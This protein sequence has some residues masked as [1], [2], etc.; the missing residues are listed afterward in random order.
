MWEQLDPAWRAAIEEAWA[1]YGAG[2]HPIGA[3]L[4]DGNGRVL[5]RGRNHVFDAEP[6]GL[7]RRN[8]LAHA[9]MN[10]LLA[11]DYHDVDPHQCVLYTTTEPCPLCMGALYM[12]GVRSLHYAARDTWCGSTNLL[13]VTPYLA[14]KPVRVSGPLP[15]VEDLV[16]VLRI[17]FHLRQDANRATEVV[18]ASRAVSASA[19][20]LGEKLAR[21]GEL[22]SL[23]LGGVSA[24]EMVGCLSRSL[25]QR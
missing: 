22:R 21:T 20:A 3:A 9:E 7:I 18:E 12:S 6:G 13:G 17:A 10:A 4:T 2:S 19:V 5:A 16:V 1:A 25:T 14:R 15:G 8:P 11:L 24:A 23:A